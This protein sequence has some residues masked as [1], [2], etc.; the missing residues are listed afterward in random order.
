[1]VTFQ[2]ILLHRADVHTIKVNLR[3][4]TSHLKTLSKQHDSAPDQSNLQ[5][6]DEIRLLTQIRARKVEVKPFEYP[7]GIFLELRVEGFLHHLP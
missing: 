4:P 1:M 2:I 5:E 6:N 7:K 3:V